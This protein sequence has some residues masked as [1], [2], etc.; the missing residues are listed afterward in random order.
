MKKIWAML[1]ALALVCAMLPSAMA[2]DLSKEA[3]GLTNNKTTVTLTVGGNQTEVAPASDVVFVLDKSISMATRAEAGAM[4]T[5]LEDE[6]LEKGLDVKVGVVVYSGTAQETYPLTKITKGVCEKIATYI[7]GIQYKSGTNLEAGIRAGIDMLEGDSSSVTS[8]N[9]HLVLVSDGVTYL[10]GTGTPQSIYVNLDNT[11]AASVDYV[12]DYWAYHREIS[13]DDYSAYTDA[14][15]WIAT[16]EANGIQKLITTYQ[17]DYIGTDGNDIEPFVPVPIDNK[18]ELNDG[19]FVAPYSSLEAAIYMGGKAWQQ[20]ADKGYNLYAY[21]PDD[22]LTGNEDGSQYY[23]W[24][25]T[26][27]KGLEKIGNTYTEVYTDTP[28]GVDGMFDGIKNSIL[29]EIQ[30]GTVK[31]PIGYY[32]TFDGLDTVKLTVGNVPVSRDDSAPDGY[33]VSFDGG[34]YLVKYDSEDG[35]KG[36]IT[37][38][39]KTPVEQGKAVALSYGLTVDQSKVPTDRYVDA[40][41]NGETTLTYEP[42]TGGKEIAEFDV[43]EFTLGKKESIPTPDKE[44]NGKETIGDVATGDIIPFTITTSLPETIAGANADEH[45]MLIF[46]DT[47]TGLELVDGTMKLT[48]NDVTINPTY[49][50]IEDASTTDPKYLREGNTFAVAVNLSAINTDGSLDGLLGEEVVVLSYEGKVTAGMGSEV[51]N[52]AWVNDSN[53]DTTPGKVTITTGG[54]GTL[55]YTI[56]GAVLLAAAGVLFVVNRRKTAG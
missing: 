17:R 42:T 14:A 43:P 50:E 45:T 41:T 32:Y 34:K 6:V 46:R 28:N 36:T 26:F 31:D 30:S 48:I 56:G 25:P 2:V 44:A 16:A 4:L 23:P 38:D 51:N 9:K 47:M 29:Y 39:I 7:D 20:A 40:P 1:T 52:E 21:A 18:I 24:A 27:I 22:Y 49:Y 35:P 53:S 10:W 5:S 13:V 3:S 33:D 55:M 8:A 15:K 12:N 54:S 11:R 37:W 19:S